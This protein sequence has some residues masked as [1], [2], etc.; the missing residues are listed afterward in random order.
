RYRSESF[1]LA[2]GD[3]LLCVTDGV[4]ERRNGSRQFDDD[5]GLAAVLAACAGLGAA[6]VAER[7]RRA[8]HEYDVAPPDDDL[9]VL[10]LQ[11]Q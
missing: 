11:A 9:A 4:T 6:G 1:R 7:V 8:V 3:T 2:P 5:D 10:V